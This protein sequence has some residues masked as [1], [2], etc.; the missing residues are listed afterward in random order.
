MGTN[1]NP[2]LL[3]GPLVLLVIL[4]I[5]DSIKQLYVIGI[6]R[7]LFPDFF[8]HFC[9]FSQVKKIISP[10]EGFMQILFPDHL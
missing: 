4:E 9:P 7:V 10:E 1:S 5:F 8:C 3:G 2:Q 6:L